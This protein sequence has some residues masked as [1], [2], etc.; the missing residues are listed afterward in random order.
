MAEEPEKT[1]QNW[2]RNPDG[3]FKE[4]HE[5]TGGRPQGSGIS[6]TTEIKN[7]LNE[8]PSGQKATFLELLIDQILKQAIENGNPQMIARIWQYID[9]MPKQAI[10]EPIDARK[11]IH[12]YIPEEDSKEKIT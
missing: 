2:D 11:F 4:G 12:Y 3:T 8:C 7:K 9:G 6:I 10:E 1:G 5:G